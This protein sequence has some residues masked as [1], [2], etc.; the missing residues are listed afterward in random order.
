MKLYFAGA[1]TQDYAS[2][3]DIA[4]VKRRLLS[5]W[6]MPT[7]LKEKKVKIADYYGQ[8]KDIF[9]DS[10]AYTAFTQETTVDIIEYIEFLKFHEP[11]VY[12]NLDDIASWEQTLKNQKLMEQAGLKPLPVW[13]AKEPFQAL[14][15]YVGS[16][17][18]VGIGFATLNSS[19]ERKQLAKTLVTNFPDKKFHLFALTHLDILAEYDFYSA[20]STGWVLRASKFATIDTPFGYVSFS[21]EHAS[22]TSGKF[23]DNMDAKEQAQLDTY[24]RAFG[25]G[26]EDLGVHYKRSWIMRAYYQALYFKFFEQACNDLRKEGVPATTHMLDKYFRSKRRMW[27][28]VKHL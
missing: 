8:E 1:E 19:G 18:Y 14:K 3:L 22:E 7:Q 26:V 20:D 23:Y 2:I 9:I 10:G 13:H 27:K 11:T 16:Y 28:I 5:F 17:D 15:D 25:L 4:G 24:L 12:A 6:Y 21:K